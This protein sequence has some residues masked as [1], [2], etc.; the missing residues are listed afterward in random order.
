MVHILELLDEL[1]RDN[2]ITLEGMDKERL[3]FHDPCQ[4]VRRGGIMQEP[5]ELLNSVSADFVEMPSAGKWNWCCGGGGGVSANPEADALRL[6]T[7]SIKKEQLEKT[8][9][10]KMVTCCSNCRN[11]LE[12]GIEEYEMNVEVV[13]LT[14]LIAEHLKQ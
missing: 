2:R 3:T 11:M 8:G 12:D 10:K 9:A 14:E 7:F 13:G 4:L 5:R 6:K 1:K